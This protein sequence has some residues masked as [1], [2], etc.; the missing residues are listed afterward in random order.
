MTT[1]TRLDGCNRVVSIHSGHFQELTD[2]PGVHCMT[3]FLG[4]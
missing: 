1:D 4:T 3:E 2:I